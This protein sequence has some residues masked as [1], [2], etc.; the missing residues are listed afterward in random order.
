MLF[1]VTFVAVA[2]ILISI[3]PVHADQFDYFTAAQNSGVLHY[4]RTIDSYHTDK[5]VK[6]LGEG[7]LRNALDDLNYTLDRFPNHARALMIVKNVAQHTKNPSFGYPYFERALALFPSYAMTHAQ[8]GDYLV[9]FQ[10]FDKGIAELKRAI[11]MDPK[12]VGAHVL[13]AKAYYQKGDLEEA[14]KAAAEARNL[15]YAG[16]IPGESAQK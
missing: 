15:G 5:V 8:Y 9:D 10:Q 7:R 6:A 13:L 4:L 11:E 3:D 16:V 2:M 12:L 14:R 1:R